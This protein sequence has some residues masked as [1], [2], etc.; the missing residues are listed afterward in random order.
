VATVSVIIPT[1][2]R[3]DL[4]IGTVNSVLEQDVDDLEVIVADDGST[5]GIEKLFDNV[6][7]RVRYVRLPHRGGPSPT[8]NGGSAQATGEFILFLDS[9]DRLLPGRIRKGLQ[10]FEDPGVTFNYCRLLIVDSSTGS[11]TV[12][13]NEPRPETMIGD[14]IGGRYLPT[15]A[16]F[17]RASALPDPPFDEEML[18]AEDQYL[19]LQLAAAG[20]G[21]FINEPLVQF[22]QH[23]GERITDNPDRAAGL[24]RVDSLELF[25]RRA[26]K[27]AADA[28]VPCDARRRGWAY[29]AALIADYCRYFDL[30]ARAL[31]WY[32]TSM[33]YRPLNRQSIAGMLRLPVPLFVRKKLRTLKG[34]T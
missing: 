20:T 19:W 11:E 16:F 28:K 26:R 9:D 30:K 17:M 25:Y 15:S 2:N 7:E 21:T 33:R 5:D 32:L 8:R 18:T 4:V 3:R 6:D 29:T 22:V 12:S 1:Y 14:I 31:R 23:Q 34:T 27:I 24:R 10:T 13:H